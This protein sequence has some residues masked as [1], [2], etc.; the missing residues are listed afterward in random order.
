MNP[1]I[2]TLPCMQPY[3]VQNLVEVSKQKKSKCPKMFEENT[4]IPCHPHL[5]AFHL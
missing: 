1:Q 4:F 3:R 2:H 5:D